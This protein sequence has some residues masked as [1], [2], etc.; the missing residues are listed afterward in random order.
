MDV[1]VGH[2]GEETPRRFALGSR[3]VEVLEVVDAGTAPTTATSR[4]AGTTEPSTSF[5]TTNPRIA[6]RSSCSPA[7]LEEVYL[8]GFLGCLAGSQATE[9][10]FSDPRVAKTLAGCEVRGRVLGR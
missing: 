3:Q 2:R 1:H 9:T 7:S 5:A 4:S 10:P 6:G 8:E